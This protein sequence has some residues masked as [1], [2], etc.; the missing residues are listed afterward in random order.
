MAGRAGLEPELLDLETSVLPLN[1]LPGGAWW[2]RTTSHARPQVYSP[3][4]YRSAKS[5][6]QNE[7]YHDH[8]L[9][10]N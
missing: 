1:Y 3:V 6:V 4:P 5:P 10:V 9:P 8:S 7:W 2:S